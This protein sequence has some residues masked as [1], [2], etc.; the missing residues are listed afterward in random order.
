MLIEKMEIFRTRLRCKKPFR[1]ATGVSDQCEGILVKLTTDGGAAGWGEASPDPYLTG[2]TMDG[3]VSLLVH[4]LFPV[5]RGLSPWQ[6]EEIHR[7]M[8]AACVANPSAR[9]AIDLACHDLIA[10]QAGVSLVSFLGGSSG[11]VLTNYSIGLC[12]AEEAA[13]E[14]RRIIESGYRAVKL[15]VGNDPEEDY[16][17][18]KAVRSSIGPEVPLRIDAN[19][20]WTYS[21]ALRALTRIEPFGVELIEQP[22]A[23]WDYEGMARLRER[24]TPPIA[25]DEGVHSP[26][27][28]ARAIAAGAVDIINIKLMK[29][30]GLY[31]ARSIVAQARAHGVALMVGG[32]VGESRLAVSAATALAAAYRFEFADLD[33]DLLLAE[34][35]V[36]EG[37][38]TLDGSER[39]LPDL[40]GLGVQKLDESRLTSEAQPLPR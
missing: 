22:I 12:T 3:V 11:R 38:V 9:C 6:L 7:R 34:D 32:M 4:D 36:A 31:P 39:V 30:G 15:K 25:A 17:R 10:R 21:Q 40:P 1:I 33:A 26:R 35:A 5:V 23:R 37:G 8:A 29:S 14:A 20:G 19:E 13:K 18:V 27:D 28:A 24:V 2:E 16:A